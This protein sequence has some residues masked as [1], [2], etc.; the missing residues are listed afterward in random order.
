MRRST[1]RT[2]VSPS[3][4]TSPSW[5]TRRNLP[6][7]ASGRSPISSRKSVPPDDSSTR[8]RRSRSAPVKAPRAWANSSP[9][10]GGPGSGATFPAREGPR[11]PER[12]GRSTAPISFPAPR[13]PTRSTEIFDRATRAAFANR[14]RV[15]KSSATTVGGAAIGTP[16]GSG[17]APCSSS[18]EKRSSARA[19][20]ARAATRR[21]SL[22]SGPATDVAK[23]AG[24]RPDHSRTRRTAVPAPVPDAA[25]RSR[26]AFAA[27]GTARP[28]ARAVSASRRTR[29]S[30]A[31]AP[32][33]SREGR[34][35]SREAEATS[36]SRR[37]LV[38]VEKR[39]L[40]KARDR[41]QNLTVP[42]SRAL[43]RENPLEDAAG[44]REVA[45]PKEE[46][47]AVPE[48]REVPLFVPARG[49]KS[50]RGLELPGRDLEPAA[51][52]RRVRHVVGRVRALQR[53]AG[54][55]LGT[56][57]EHDRLVGAAEVV[58]EIARGAR[59]LPREPIVLD[60]GQQR[61]RLGESGARGVVVVRAFVKLRAEQLRPEAERDGRPREARRSTL[62][63]APG[64][65]V[66]SG[67]DEN[68]GARDVLLGRA[69]R[70]ERESATFL[71][72][73]DER[74]GRSEPLVEWDAGD[75]VGGDPPR[76]GAR[77]FRAARPLQDPHREKRPP[78]IGLRPRGAR[79]EFRG[80][81]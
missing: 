26:A 52:E 56:P 42:P 79:E 33:R 51:V 9:P 64:L 66:T 36:R 4:L 76:H 29:S 7:R 62:E 23:N 21:A 65:G 39:E 41:E 53:A 22:R 43:M 15:A 19:R 49:I 16:G 32:D 59:H 57:K 3:R 28:E 25:R 47:D 35:A 55:R 5:R 78:E 24:K 46:V 61:L 67:F 58:R 74:A 38:S 10:A 70:A 75:H 37:A 44:G 50:Q 48:C 11:R 8:P 27:S 2:A 69:S 60:A 34:P 12:G 18:R 81:G 80:R 68:P 14:S 30:A 6:W 77:A 20:P 71:A 73:A 1:R 72:Q 31:K 17:G 54:E 45:D 40:L 63:H 13:S